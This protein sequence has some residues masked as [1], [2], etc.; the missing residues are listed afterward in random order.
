MI[1]KIEDDLRR[2]QKLRVIEPVETAEFGATSIV[3][4]PKP[5]GAVR[6]CGDFKVTTNTYADMQHYPL[7][8]FEELRAALAGGKIFSKVDLADAHLQLEVDSESRKY[9]VLSTQKGLFRFTRLPFGFYGA[10]AIFQSAIDSILQGLPG[11]VAYLDDI[12][13]TGTTE[14]EHLDRLR[15]LFTRL[16]QAGLKHKREKCQ[17]CRESLT[18]L[19]HVIDANGTR[20]DP[21]TLRAIVDCPVPK[22]ASQLRSFLGM[23]N[24]Y[25][26]FVPNLSTAAGSLYNLTKKDV[27]FCW[28]QAHQMAFD[29]LKRILVS[30]KLLAHYDPYLILG[31]SADASSYGI[32]AVLFHIEPNG[33]ERPIYYSSRVL[34]DAEKNYS[35][36]EKEGLA[37]IF[38]MKRF[39]RFVTGRHF[40]LFTDHRPLLK[41]FGQQESTPSTT[42]ARLQRWSLL[43]APLITRLRLRSRLIMRTPTDSLVILL[44]QARAWIWRSPAFSTKC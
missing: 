42:S 26:K 43:S 24:Y 28:T 30:D 37:I 19:G 36:V 17:F 22:D 20:P 33:V 7:P 44:T 15:A 25:G 1:A 38:A 2:L 11:V 5:N 32:G 41:I 21:E 6:I 39:Q 23:V 4:V 9:L 35:Q 8:H 12:L 29:S 13:V 31:I 40:F 16:R 18:Y 27:K 34:S 10:P 14:A 3:P